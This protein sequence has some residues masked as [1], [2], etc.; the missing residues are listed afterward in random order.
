MKRTTSE[1][2][3]QIKVLLNELEQ[4]AGLENGEAG[5]V[6]MTTSQKKISGCAGII[7]NL[8]D[9]NFFN[10]PKDRAEVEKKLKEEGHPYSPQ[11]ISM[12]LLNLIKRRVLR[13]VKENG[14]WQ[15]LKRI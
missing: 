4:N 5:K 1:V 3:A 8:I 9:E 6:V 10:T 2:I 7:Q 11:L 12:N 13:R 15:Y 14:Q